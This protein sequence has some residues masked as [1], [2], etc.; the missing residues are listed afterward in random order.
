MYHVKRMENTA[1]PLIRAE[2]EPS[3]TNQKNMNFRSSLLLVRIT[4]ESFK[5][6]NEP[7]HCCN[8]QRIGH[9]KLYCLRTPRC[10][11]CGH[12]H[13]SDSFPLPKTEPSKCA[14]CG[15]LHPANYRDCEAFW[16]LH[17]VHPHLFLHKHTRLGCHDPMQLYFNPLESKLHH[18]HWW[19]RSNRAFHRVTVY[20]QKQNLLRSLLC[21]ALLALKFCICQHV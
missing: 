3:G 1:R 17:E 19:N 7:P 9:T 13:P 14:N 21:Y 8:C 16:K 6:R 15:G 5:P 20:P 4:V 10:I 11:T 12:K 18:Y 2:L